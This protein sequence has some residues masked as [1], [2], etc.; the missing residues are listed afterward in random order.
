[1]N[2]RNTGKKQKKSNTIL[3]ED[4]VGLVQGAEKVCCKLCS[5]D[6]VPVLRESAEILLKELLMQAA[7]SADL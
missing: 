3:L 1:M 5:V 6:V 2:V 4:L 7:H